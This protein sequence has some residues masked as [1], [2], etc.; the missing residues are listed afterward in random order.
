MHTLDGKSDIMV[1]RLLVWLIS[2]KATITFR[3]CTKS[4]ASNELININW[5]TE[6]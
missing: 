3:I 2:A 1:L 6:L 4:Y 5:N